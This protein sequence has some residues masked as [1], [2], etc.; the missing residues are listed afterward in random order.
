MEYLEGE[1]LKHAIAGRA[2]NAGQ[3]KPMELER[4]LGIAIEVAD[5][6]DAAHTKGIVHRDI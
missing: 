3:G 4:L 1:T 6:L 2:I 5:A